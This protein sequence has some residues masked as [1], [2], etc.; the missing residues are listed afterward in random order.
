M[1]LF[2]LAKVSNPRFFKENRLDPHSGHKYFS[3]LENAETGEEEFSYSL[4][5]IWKF[6][7]AKNPELIPEKFIENDFCVSGWDDI[8]VP[9]CMQLE[10]Y[11]KPQ[12][13]NYEY[14]W[15]GRENVEP[16][17]M[18]T[19]FNPCGCYVNIFEIPKFMENKNIRI[20]FDGVESAMALWINGKYVG[21]SED[22]FTTSEF[23]ITS[24][25]NKGINRLSMIVYK[26]CG[27][28]HIDDQDFFRFSGIFRDVTLRCFGTAHINDIKV[29]TDLDEE[30]KNSILKVN[31]KVV[32]KVDGAS[33]SYVL[34]LNGNE[35]A[36]ATSAITEDTVE[37]PVDDPIKWNAEHPV[38][39]D[40]FV[41]LNKGT[42]LVEVSK[43]KVG[44]RK[45]E[46]K[47]GLMLI[48]GKRIVFN[49][50]N[51]HEFD[52]YNGRVVSFDETKADIINMKKNNINALR[53]CHYPDSEYVYD[54]CDEYG[55]YVICENNMESHGSW[56]NISAGMTTVEK[57]VPGDNP[58]YA[59]II[60]DRA[61]S[62]FEKEKNHPS[63]LIWSC[64]NESFGGLN[65]FN[66]SQHF[67]ELDKTRLVH[68][69]GIFNDR[70]YPDTSDMESQMYTPVE[71]IKKF[72][73]EN[74]EKPFIC[75][76][77]TH[78][79]GN[80][81]G[82][83]FKYTDLSETEPRYQGGFIWDY[84]DQAIATKDRYG[85][86]YFGYGGDFD[87]RPCDYEFSGDGICFADHTPTTKMPSVKY[88]YQQIKV[89]FEDNKAVIR[90]LSLFTDTD[91]YD[92]I[93]TYSKD[94]VVYKKD[95]TCVSI[96]PMETGEIYLDELLADDGVYTINLSFVLRENTLYADA[97]YEVAF[98]EKTVDVKNHDT[99]LCKP[100]SKV[101]EEAFKII[102]GGYNVG[103]KGLHFSALFS[104]LYGGLTSYKFAGKERIDLIPKPNF[105]RA[106]TDN[107]RGNSMPQRYAQW[108]IASLYSSAQNPDNHFESP[109]S[110]ETGK[111]YAKIGYKYY[112]PTN[113]ANVCEVIYTVTPDGMVK[114]NMSI[115]GKDGLCDMPEFG[116][117]FVM[118]ADLENV[119]WFGLGPAETYADR[120][121]GAKMSLYSNKVIDNMVPHLRPQECGN[122]M[123]VY[124]ASVTDMKGR[125]VEFFGNGMNFS[126]LPYTPHEIENTRHHFEL[127]PVHHTVVR[128]SKAQ[129]GIAGDDTW[130]A[131]THPEFLLPA[132]ELVQFEFS[133][134]GI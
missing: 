55:I 63:V 11:D 105:W 133:F 8:Y 102:P 127:P 128:V 31:T 30:Y 22:S 109:M 101:E 35:I 110:I 84:V 96:A 33:L 37:I 59:D 91:E 129:M 54:L 71:G 18:P 23:D 13:A 16:G 41:C 98:G 86:E 50:V 12:Y 25:V 27:S 20:A 47:D 80:S 17:S 92:L 126:A 82:A 118:N 99:E 49:G 111:D 2:D 1:S 124:K 130:G 107:D 88:N 52:V 115:E 94:G 42:E 5:G 95:E 104:G 103:V 116:M 85:K 66:L 89:A 7:Y 114:V 117:M 113:P 75:C 81:C 34:K 72:L 44:F 21:Y 119:K 68:Y 60:I 15:D 97:G 64:G 125:G 112:L 70:R 77:Y 67:R 122:K 3:S 62:M 9:A 38:L 93:I 53:T 29:I 74:T 134:K 26:W 123:N 121:Q 83:M 131:K 45:F 4:N 65:I 132:D 106:P 46:L 51:R 32:G 79:M 78:A 90:N 10:G 73:Q 43:I 19:E 48:N 61:D 57:V 76:E 100:W 28:C 87:D 56:A 6:F 36:T 40:L 14:P 120:T 24:Y 69:E 58:D 108:K 39:Y